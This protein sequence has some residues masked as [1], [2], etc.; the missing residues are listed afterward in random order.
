MKNIPYF[1]TITILVVLPWF[2]IPKGFVYT[3]EEP[4][5]INYDIKLEKASTM[6][7]KDYG[8]GGAG[9]PSNQSLLIPNAIFYDAVREL[10]I[11]RSSTQKLFI[12]FTFLS[13]AVGFGLFSS[14]FTRNSFIKSLGLLIYLFNFYT[15][16]SFGYTAKI[17]QLILMPPIFYLTY[18]YLKSREIKYLLQN[19]I[20][21][22]AFQG[23]FTNL[24]L[25]VTS[26]SIYPLAFLY[27]LFSEKNWTMKNALRD[28]LTLLLIALPILVPHSII[29]R[30]VLVAMQEK[31][32]LF[33]FSAI[34]TTFD[35]LFQ[36]RGAWW[37]KSGHLGIYYFNLWGFYGHP[38]TII[39]TIIAIGTIVL[40]SVRVSW[41]RNVRSMI[42]S[43]YWLT[44]YV[45]GLGLA[46]GFYF[47]PGFYQWLMDKIPLMV[48]FRE[49]WAKFVP[50]V[51]F[52]ISAMTL[53]VLDFFSKSD[54]RKLFAISIILLLHIS[55]QSYPFI[56]RKIIDKEATGWKRRL[57]K[58]PDYWEEY[59][60]WTKKNQKV[61][62]PIPFGAT[63]FNSLYNWYPRETGNTILPMPCIL[64][65]T[66][67]ICDNNFDKYTS[68]L[69]SFVDKKSFDLVR[70]G[71]IDFILTQDD[72]DTT[73]YGN[74]F[75][76]QKDEIKEFVDPNPVAT[77]GGKL[78]LFQIKEKYNRPTIYATQNILTVDKNARIDNLPIS[79]F[80][81]QGVF[82]FTDAPV[83]AINKTVNPK[84]IFQKLS[85][86][87]YHV[88]V[89]NASE[90]FVLVFNQTY[91]KDW[92]IILNDKFLAPPHFIVNGFANA[93]YIDP[94]PICDK[95]PCEI[96]LDIKFG[97]QKYFLIS[98]YVN[99]GLFIIA[100]VSLL[101][102]SVKKI[103]RKK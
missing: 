51:V 35:L 13:I 102:L 25:A 9:D 79:D 66:N 59:S 46:S 44:F 72:L 6:W 68:I 24:P 80:G 38:L 37:E 64:G 57:V 12:S 88:K 94:K 81:E 14:L 95:T 87:E 53:V 86:A 83:P 74:Q 48:M 62:L 75:D 91:A 15:G 20:W 7:T 5:F 54:H 69:K 8:F 17:L 40:C 28:F 45:L 85:Q 32:N 101:A 84:T 36:F 43:T 90:P 71:G 11:D 70:L 29:Y 49:P 27:Y 2:W 3:S 89:I 18:M 82:V 96:D 10:G 47:F 41:E 97:P 67:V 16:S 58:I 31:P 92:K 63:P 60:K 93:W 42:K 1:L 65:N 52:S 77:F 98:M 30:T 23:I 56:S 103:F 4:N 19:Y 61:I 21:L 33:V 55:V 22:F 78:R 99:I 76:W 73:G 100:V 39:S 34:G 26:L 50:Y